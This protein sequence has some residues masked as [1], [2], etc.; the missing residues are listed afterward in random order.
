MNK[1]YEDVISKGVNQLW[2]YA[3]LTAVPFYEA[4]GWR[5]MGKTKRGNLE[6]VKM[7]KDL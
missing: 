7:E 6:C 3:S 5:K 1:A 4:E 2:L